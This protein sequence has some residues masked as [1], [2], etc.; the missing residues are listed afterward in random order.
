MTPSE[1]DV[2]EYVIQCARESARHDDGGLAEESEDASDGNTSLVG[3]GLL[4]SMGFMN[5][6]V[7]VEDRFDVEVDLDN[8]EPSVFT[9]VDGLTEAVLRSIANAG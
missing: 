3:S 9:T 7:K 4:D 6:L 1:A 8:S 5:L 2:K